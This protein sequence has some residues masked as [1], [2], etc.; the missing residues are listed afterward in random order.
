MQEVFV[1]QFDAFHGRFLVSIAPDVDNAEAV[2]LFDARG[3]RWK[4]LRN[5]SS[6]LFT[7]ANLKKVLPVLTDSV[8]VMV[9]RVETKTSESECLN[10][11]PFFQELTMDVILRVAFGESRSQQGEQNEVLDVAKA[12]FAQE[13]LSFFIL[14][15]DIFPALAPIIRKLWL[16]SSMFK[17]NNEL[18]MTEK[19]RK[20]VEERRKTRTGGKKENNRRVDFVD[21]FL[22]A[23]CEVSALD[24]E[25][26]DFDSR[27][28]K[29]GKKLSTEEIVLQCLVFL[30]AGYDTTANA[31][32]FTTFCLA[33]NPEAQKKVQEEID[34][35]FGED[36]EVTYEKVHKLI[37]LDWVMKETLRLYPLAALGVSRE[38][39]KT[40]QLENWKIEKG[41]LVLADVLSTQ[42]DP[43]LWG[44]DA[45]EFRPERW[46][47]GKLNRHPMAWTPFGAGPRS[48][49]GLRFAYLEE[50]VAMSR[51]LRRNSI[52]A[53]KETEL[54]LVGATVLNPEAVNVKVVPR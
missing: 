48:C 26:G 13:G 53:V 15:A 16:A 54:K 35:V 22:D 27:G 49:V 31:L 43:K 17:R 20:V 6:P 39:M 21:M 42:R 33:K 14:L 25:Q 7:I 10:I 46:E 45:D 34:F 12:M 41:T 4:R 36:D 38:C 28:S 32:S 24:N 8:D 44:D 19:L 40:T 1:K 18:F 30:L 11:V 37:Y 5:L 50:K 3:K 23:E 2:H 9:N 47:S 51:L 52:L 29:V